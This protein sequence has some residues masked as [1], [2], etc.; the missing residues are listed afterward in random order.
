MR[1]LITS[2]CI[3][4]S[5]NLLGQISITKS[6][7]PGAND[8]IRISQARVIDVSS[9]IAKK[10]SNTWNFSKL[11]PTSQNLTSYKS[12]FQT[13]YA[14][15]FINKLGLKT[16]DSLGIGIAQFKN[17]YTF[18]T[19]TNAVY[20]A[21][22]LGYSYSGIPLAAN[23]IDDDEIYNLP[24]NY[25]DSTTNTFDFK[26]ALPIGNLFSVKQTGTRTNEVDGY[27][28]I[29]TPYKTYP[30]ALRVKTTIKGV[31][32]F[33]TQF[34]SL[35][36]PRNQVI[37]KWLSKG[38]KAPVLEIIGN[39]VGGRFTVT[40]INFRDQY[41]KLT[42]PGFLRSNFSVNSSSGQVD[43][44]TF[45]FTNLTT[46]ITG[47]STWSISPNAF[48][49]VNGSNANSENPQVVFEKTGVYSVSLA[50]VVGPNNDD[51]TATNLITIG[52]NG[53]KDISISQSLFPNPN[54][55]VFYLTNGLWTILKVV[56]AN[57]QEVPFKQD[58]KKVDLK[59]ISN[60]SYVV[61][62]LNSAGHIKS[63]MILINK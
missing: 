56:N 47:N 40:Q 61:M 54:H 59:N 62:M 24:L 3:L 17:I 4:F 35:G 49:F 46:P 14:F 51:T 9:E 63:G 60:G 48:K 36:F 50:S 10:G 5:L 43:A 30:N 1:Y 57:G 32:S 13:P 45:T 21:E 20:K 52:T 29:S 8:T 22:G 15:Y 12:S 16:A 34:I 41:R 11:K 39:E 37:Y 25:E 44:D 31:D 58:G 19:S 28:S 33:I 26:F 6:D 38:E 2:L 18:Y 55:G 42:N 7:M 27:G 53:R 23:Y